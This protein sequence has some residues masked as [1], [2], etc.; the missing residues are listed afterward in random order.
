MS[1]RRGPLV[2]LAIIVGI[3]VAGPWLGLRDPEAQPAGSVLAELPPWARVDAAALADG[4][5]LYADELGVPAGGELPYRRGE[6]WETIA[7]ERLSG[8]GEES[9]RRRPLFVLGTD[10]FG[11]DLLSRLVH[12]ARISLWIGLLAAAMAMGIGSAV[13]L[14]A[15]FAGGWVD[16]VLMRATDV[17]LAIP[18][19]FLALLLVA[20]YGRSLT[21]TVVVLGATTWMA[22]ARLVRGQVLSLR[23]RDFVHAARAAGA[24]PLR[25]MVAHL[26]PSTLGPIRVEGTLR[27]ADAILLE[28]ALSFLSLGVQPPHPSW[29]NLILDGKNRLLDAPWIALFPGLAVVITVVALQQLGEASGNRPARAR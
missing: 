21:A 27:V 24:T 2:V 14:L 6:R 17:A 28:A 23:E 22:A 15:G 18:R 16:G 26:L 10:A 8:A 5:L 29:G 11:R 1:G 19:L 7:V 12:G 9:W 20:L 13:G 3:A 25:T 4:S